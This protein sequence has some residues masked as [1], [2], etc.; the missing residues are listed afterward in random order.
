MYDAKDREMEE[1]CLGT[2]CLYNIFVNLK[3]LKAKADV[4]GW[5]ESQT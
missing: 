4:S 2:S 1:G 3:S 5:Y